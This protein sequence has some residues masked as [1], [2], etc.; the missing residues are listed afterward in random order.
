MR[1]LLPLFGSP[2]MTTTL[3]VAIAVILLAA[4]FTIINAQQPGQQLTS[5]PG[6]IGNRPAATARTTFQSTNDSFRI[7]VPGGWVIQ[8]VNNTGAALSKEGT[9]GYGMLAQLCPMEES[10]QQGAAFST[11]AS[12]G[13]PNSSNNTCSNSCQGAQ[14]VIYIIRYPDLVTRIQPAIMLL[15][16][17][18]RSC[19]K[20]DIESSRQ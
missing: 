8:D 14:H 16:T 3:T 4:N 15:H 17:I 9:L 20:L 11:D 10:Q 2:T 6:V 13:S 5:Q 18:C 1:A 12:G 19:R 7:Q